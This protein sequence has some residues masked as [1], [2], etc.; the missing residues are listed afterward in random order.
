MKTAYRLASLA[1]RAALA[2]P[3]AMPKFWRPSTTPQQRLDAQ[4]IHWDLIDR[5]TAGTAD[6]ADLWDWM[7]TGFTYSQLMRLLA[8]DGTE[9]TVEAM[10]AVVDQLNTY[11]A[12]TQR[13][14]RTGRAGF[15]AAE[16]LIAR[17]AASVFDSLIELDRYGLAEK[18]ALWSTQQMVIVRKKMLREACAA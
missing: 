12:I 18:A 6:R 1:K 9:F 2:Q 15:S 5:F 14:Q 16:L 11:D 17:A 10:T 8:E 7:E 13:F 3:K 4:L